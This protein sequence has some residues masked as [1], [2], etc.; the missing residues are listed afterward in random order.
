[1]TTPTRRTRQSYRFAACAVI[2]SSTL[3][4]GIAGG[5]QP[6]SASTGNPSD[7]VAVVIEGQGN[8]HGR[9]LSQYGSLGW[10]TIHNRDWTWILDHYYGGTIA[11]TA[12]AGLRITVSLAAFDGRQTAVVAANSNATWVGGTAGSFGSL[13][14]RE[15]ASSGTTATYKVWGNASRTCPSATDSLSSWRYLG[16]MKASFNAA[17]PRF[18]VAG[19][20]DPNTPVGSLLGVC[21]VSGAIR[22]YRGQIYATNRSDGA[23]RTIND[24]GI[25][26]YLRGVVPRESP[27]SWADR[28]GGAGINALRAQSVAARSYALAQGGTYAGKR[29]PHA[30]TCD[31]D[32]CQVYGGAGTRVNATASVVV[33]EDPRTDRAIADTAGVIRIREAFPLNPVSTEFSSSNGDRTAG[34]NFVPVDDDG[35][36]QDSNPWSRWTRI[37]SAPALA[38]RYGLSKITK[39]E[40][41]TDTSIS[42]GLYG[43]TPAWAVS[44]KLFDGTRSVT[45]KASDLR[46]AFGFPS[47][48]IRARLVTRD[49]ASNDDFVF[50]G[51]SV[52]ASVAANDATGMLPTLLDR[53]FNSARYDSQGYR[54]TVGNCPPATSDG[55]SIARGLSGSPDVA[56]VELGYN[57]GQSSLGAEIDQVMQALVSKGVRVVGWVTM[58]ER[59]IVNGSSPFVTGN[60]AL[61]A[62]ASRWPQLRI[63]NW[64]IHSGG[65]ANDRWFSDNVHLSP[66][67]RAQFALWLRER[68]FELSRG[69]APAVDQTVKISSL[70]NLRIPMTGNYG[71]PTSDVVAVSFNLTAVGPEGPGYMTVWPCSSQQPPTSSI[72]FTTGQTVANAVIAPVNLSADPSGSVCVAS[73][74]PSHVVI[75]VNGWFS[76]A[77]GLKTMTP[78]RAMDTRNGTG[79]VPIA[80][81]GRSGGSGA[82]LPLQMTGLNGIPATGVSAVSI[83]LTATNTSGSSGGG[84]V[85]A[86]PCGTTP[87][88][89]SNLNFVSGRTVANGVVVPVSATGSVCFFVDGE[90]DLI[91]DVNGWFSTGSG[92][93]SIPPTR[94]FDTRDGRGGVLNSRLGTA[95]GA[96]DAVELPVVSR[97][98]LPGSG[99]G[100]IFINLTA[101]DPPNN[102]QGGYVTAY[103]CS[104]QRP[105]ASNLNFVGS[106]TIANSV[107]AQVSSQG[108]VCFFVDGATHLLADISGWIPSGAGFSPVAPLRI[109]DT[110]ENLGP[111]PGS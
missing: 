19:G 79:G 74:Q 59:R 6:V 7:A 91:V 48:S 1:M 68:A 3:V 33:L 34:I 11:G 88:L 31:T 41:V 9:G 45:V 111:V 105:L 50:I 81:V 28:A 52:G 17:G 98:S 27:A 75:D 94:M 56:I 29:Y 24:I 2:L 26:S 57:D 96:V 22:H 60:Q 71:I 108:A 83:N 73:T 53:V 107:I 104:A 37:H 39:V 12:P 18:A 63:L 62:A 72:N 23:N 43:V 99:V 32:S 110:R 86:Y 61:R 77:S 16:E 25:E 42:P 82:P 84:Y 106:Q 80:R 95:S 36:K 13:V 89:A 10:A 100:S 78:V 76:A 102:G 47:S 67:G 97:W 35:D 38:S 30:K 8:G 51:D 66:T 4:T 21:D 64:D 109:V 87:P 103:P 46:S 58:S 85:T 49:Y 92:F 15:V 44:V 5:V 55:L 40:M 93:R 20:D 14:A 70:R 65:S 101:T 54:C 69:E 90:A